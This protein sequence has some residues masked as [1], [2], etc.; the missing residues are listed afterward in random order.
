MVK[1]PQPFQNDQ[2]QSHPPSPSLH[3]HHLICPHLHSHNLDKPPPLPKLCLLSLLLLSQN[4]ISLKSPLLV[5]PHFTVP[6]PTFSPPH[7]PQVSLQ[8]LLLLF[9]QQSLL[10]SMPP[11]TLPLFHQTLPPLPLFNTHEHFPLVQ[12]PFAK[13][14]GS[15]QA[16]F[17]SLPL[18][19]ILKPPLPELPKRLPNLQSS[20]NSNKPTVGDLKVSKNQLR[21]PKPNGAV[22]LNSHLLVL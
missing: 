13:Q 3:R 22:V 15:L 7:F 1:K 17:L 11:P 6:L 9:Q 2:C 21:D 20:L 5:H 12:L 8:F 19:Q 10:P 16:L 14:V 18:S 4:R